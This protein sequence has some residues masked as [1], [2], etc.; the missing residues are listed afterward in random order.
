MGRYVL[1]AVDVHSRNCVRF[2]FVREA[3]SAI[4]NTSHNDER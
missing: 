4:S 1:E 3:I 2:L